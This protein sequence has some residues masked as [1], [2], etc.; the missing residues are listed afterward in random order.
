[1]EQFALQ[2]R[3]AL[4][5]IYAALH[6]MGAREGPLITTVSFVANILS[7]LNWEAAFCLVRKKA[8]I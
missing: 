2:T 5:A 3:R 8:N 1:M 4:P 7:P 6:V